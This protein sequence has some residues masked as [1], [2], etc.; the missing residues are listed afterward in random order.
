MTAESLINVIEVSVPKD[1]VKL[2]RSDSEYSLGLSRSL[3]VSDKLNE[4]GL[5]DFGT[6]VLY[7][8]RVGL[9]SVIFSYSIYHA[10]KKKK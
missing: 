7:T 4:M 1:S 3:S 9:L 5:C 6:S 10:M 8:V 2:P